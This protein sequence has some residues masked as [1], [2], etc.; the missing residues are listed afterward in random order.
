MANNALKSTDITGTLTTTGAVTVST[1]P[2][3]VGAN[4]TSS[5]RVNC[6]G[7]AATTR[8]FAIQTAGVNRWIITASSST[9]SGSNAGSNFNLLAYDDSGTLIDIPVS[10]SR[11]A[12]STLTLSRPVSAT[13]TLAVTGNVTMPS[14]DIGGGYGSTGVTVSSAGNIQ[15]NG[16]LTVDGAQTLTG[17]TTHGGEIIAN[18]VGKGLKVKEGTN[19][20]MGL[21]TLAAGTVTVSTTAVTANSRIF[22]TPQAG[23]G[24][25]GWVRVSARS[26][27][28][29]FT[30]TSSSGTDTSTVAWIIIEPA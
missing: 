4:A 22:L 2:L 12:G 11:V 1:T 28:T 30:I 13:S 16:T 18:T 10:M 19:A 15:A 14:T 6:N 5:T 3:T 21:A 24:T 29:S 17:D 23:G 7:A 27:G 9:E 8:G 25:P 26:A 20:K